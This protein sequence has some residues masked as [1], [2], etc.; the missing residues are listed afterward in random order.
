MHHRQAAGQLTDDVQRARWREDDAAV[1]RQVAA[2]E[3]FHGQVVPAIGD[4]ADV[5]DGDDRRVAQRGDDM[6]FLDEAL[7]ERCIFRAQQHLDGHLAIQRQLG[8]QVDLG[9]SAFSE[10]LVQ[11]IARYFQ[12]PMHCRNSRLLT[13]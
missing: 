10:P 1:L 7:G 2:A 11:A 4:L 13:T 12:H 9:H 8:G 6:A 3:V 5:V